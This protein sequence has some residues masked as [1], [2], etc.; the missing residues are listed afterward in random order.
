MFSIRQREESKDCILEIAG[1]DSRL[2]SCAF[3]GSTAEGTDRWSDLYLTFGVGTEYSVQDVLNDW[4]LKM[5]HEFSAVHLFDLQSDSMTYR[6]FLLPG[7]LQVGLSFTPE[8]DFGVI[9]PRFRLL[10]GRIVQKKWPEAPTPSSLFG[11]AAH[12]LVRA[13]ICIE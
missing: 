12:Y 2:V 7:N 9:G 11:L 6:V 4:T 10:Y 13:R 3:V 8:S 5:Q 1:K